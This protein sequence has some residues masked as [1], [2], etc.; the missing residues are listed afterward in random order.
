MTAVQ[1]AGRDVQFNKKGHLASF[2]D[3]DNELAEALAAE[4]GL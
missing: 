4:D 3:W 1:I 2:G